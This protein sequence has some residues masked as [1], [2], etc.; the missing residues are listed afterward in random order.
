MLME[1]EELVERRRM[2]VWSFEKLSRAGGHGSALSLSVPH[3]QLSALP[4]V[5]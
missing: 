3:P 4:V 2:G 5:Y 1:K